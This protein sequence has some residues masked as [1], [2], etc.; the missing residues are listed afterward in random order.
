MRIRAGAHRNHLVGLGTDRRSEL[1][2]GAHKVA[3]HRRE[4]CARRFALPAPQLAFKGVGRGLCV[5]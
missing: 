3:P 5:M 1:E 2:L 4:H